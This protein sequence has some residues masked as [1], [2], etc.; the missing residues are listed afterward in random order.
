MF[1]QAGRITLDVVAND[2]SGTPVRGL[3]QQQ[4]AILDNGQPQKI[5]SFE[6]VGGARA[7]VGGLEIVLV[8]DSVNTSFR[9]VAYER[10]QIKKFLRQDGGKRAWPVSLAFFTDAGLRMQQTPSVD[11][12]ALVAGL[13]KTDTGL[14]TSRRSQGFYGALD[15]S[16]LSLRTMGEL[17]EY[18][19]KRPGRK[20]VIWVSPGWPLLSGTSMDLSPKNEQE[21]FHTIVGL[22]RQLRESRIAVYSVDPLGTGDAGTFRTFEYKQFLKGVSAPKHAQFGNL[23]LQVLSVQTGGRVLNSSNDAASEIGTCIRDASAYYVL[24]FN[25]LPGDG[26]EQYHAIQ[27]QIAG[28]EVRA[29]TRSGYYAGPVGPRTT[30]E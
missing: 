13:E 29:Q 30:P 25:A 2:K 11:G 12:N 22:S 23:A 14:R 1:G 5:L 7:A 4:F 6:A 18:E 9:N 15:R 27:V 16:Q 21:I 8:I 10:E 20:M 3:Q 17:A 26:P 19:A 28:P 24:S